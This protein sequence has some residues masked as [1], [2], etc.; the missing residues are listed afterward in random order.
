MHDFTLSYVAFSFQSN[1]VIL[2]TYLHFS[3]SLSFFMSDS[4]IIF[5]VVYLSDSLII[6]YVYLS[7][8]LIIFF[9]YLPD[10]LIIFFFVYL[11]DSLIIFFFVYLPDSLIIS[12]VYLSILFMICQWLR[13]YGRFVLSSIYLHFHPLD[14]DAPG[15]RGLVQRGLHPVR[16]LLPLRQDLGQAFGTK[17]IP[18]YLDCLPSNNCRYFSLICKKI[19]YNCSFTYFIFYSCALNLSNLAVPARLTNGVQ[20]FIGMTASTHGCGDTKY[21]KIRLKHSEG[22]WKGCEKFANEYHWPFPTKPF[23]LGRIGLEV[24]FKFF[25][26]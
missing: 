19:Y 14:L 6:F 1:V 18:K 13:S 11:S 25:Y 4:L 20:V 17:Y 3:V 22:D 16:D 26:C 2:T 21:T 23:W 12:I 9:V 10:S 7:D 8:S 15:V 24:S 5:F